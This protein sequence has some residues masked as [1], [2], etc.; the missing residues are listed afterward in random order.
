MEIMTAFR[1][2]RRIPAHRR[3]ARPDGR[4]IP[5]IT[6][7]VHE[8]G[9][10]P[11]S[12]SA[13]ASRSSR[14]RGGT[15]SPALAAAG[16]RAIAPDQRGYGGS[17][18]PE[19]IEAY[20]I[21]HLTGD[22]VGAARRARHRAR[23]VRRPRLGRTRGLAAAGAAPGRAWRAWSASTRRTCR[24]RRCAPDAAHAHARR[25]P[26]REDVR[27]LVPAAG[28]R[29]RRCS[30]RARACVFEKLLLGGV[31]PEEATARAAA[32]GFEPGDM[33]PFRRLAELPALGEPILTP[34]E[35]ERLRAHLRA[36]GLH[37]RHQLVPQHGPQLGD[38]ARPPAP[39]ASR[40][41]A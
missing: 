21:H 1:R 27:P 11:P 26:G 22:L 18:R 2:P 39:P 15:S 41:P 28:G 35:L 16:F 30:T 7:S 20:D 8:A 19:P 3:A 40:C 24:A 37:R 13:T 34:D 36:H 38:R 5:P 33:N 31:A 9:A 17:D 32:L 23:G 25:R 14:T 4:E 10:G 29:R 6:L 12:C